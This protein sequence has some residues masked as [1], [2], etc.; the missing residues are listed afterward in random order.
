LIGLP[1]HVFL[2]VDFLDESI[3]MVVHFVEYATVL[4]ALHFHIEGNQWEYLGF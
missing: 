3:G 4:P 2:E 1:G